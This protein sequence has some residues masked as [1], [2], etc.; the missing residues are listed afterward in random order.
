MKIWKPDPRHKRR[1]QPRRL[2]PRAAVLSMMPGS[3]SEGAL[4]KAASSAAVTGASAGS[5][6]ASA[7]A[8]MVKRARRLDP[9]RARAVGVYP[10]KPCS[11]GNLGVLAIGYI[12]L[13]GVSD[14]HR[15]TVSLRDVGS[16]NNDDDNNVHLV[17]RYI[18]SFSVK[19]VP[20]F[21]ITIFLTVI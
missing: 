8:A 14:L 20:C 12:R 6:A 13:D 4:G 11:A 10:E 9:A 2:V 1:N 16:T 17:S 15:L 7:A 3:S 18:I 19:V 5:H 21:F